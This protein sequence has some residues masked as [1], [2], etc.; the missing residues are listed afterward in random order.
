MDTSKYL[1]AFI[2]EA[3][4]NIHTLNQLLLELEKGK[5]SKD[6][7]GKAYRLVHTLKGNANVLGIDH[8]GDI[9][10]SMEDVLDKL[11]T[12]D[13]IPQGDVLDL[14]FEG[15][16]LVE[17]MIQELI[18]GG[19]IKTSGEKIV[20]RLRTLTSEE[21]GR[22]KKKKK[23]RKAKPAKKGSIMNND[24]IAQVEEAVKEGDS[25]LELKVSLDDKTRFK[26]GRIFQLF[27]N[28]SKIANIVTSLPDADSVD[29]DTIEL[30]VIVTTDEDPTSLSE[31][32]SDIKGIKISDISPLDLFQEED[33]EKE[34]EDVKSNSRED[35]ESPLK[36][37][38]LTKEDTV[39]VKNRHLDQ[40][41]DL[42]GEIMIS[43]IRVNQI[44][45]DLKHRDLKQ[46]LQN[47]ERL[48]SELQDTVLRMRMVPVDYIFKRFPRM[49]RDMAKERGK[50]I[51][52]RMMGNDMEIDRSLLDDIGDSLVHAVRNAIDHGIE[53]ESVRKK[54]GKKPRGSLKVSAY[55]EQSNIV[56]AIEDDGRG[57]DTKKI[58][59][60]AISKGVL[61]KEEIRDL[62]ERQVLSLAF[63]PGV[64]TAAKVTEVSGRGVGL[65]VVKT[66][67]ESLSGTVKV[68]TEKDKFTRIIM[69]LPPSMSIISAMLVEVNQEKYGIPLENVNETTRIPAKDIHEFSKS[70]VFRLRDE[71][72]PILNV[73][74]Q[75]GGNLESLTEDMPVVIVEKD[76][77]RAGLIVSKL[78]G[79]Q[80][81]VVKT[82]GKELA[83]QRYF[84]GATILGDGRV[85][86]ILDVGAL[87]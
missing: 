20:K 14:L 29:D 36:T 13:E 28:M 38:G 27:R 25:V 68:E 67:I 74:E 66:K 83:G 35:D 15:S 63:R 59:S 87:I 64:S 19:A 55:R 5:Y 34:S 47:R 22:T 4:E 71:I 45:I 11:K 7:M 39:R 76:D 51:D 37:K 75:F 9:A 41:L 33:S 3:R 79:Q 85:A 82:M 80:E 52:F 8:I 40:L 62:D 49:V 48:M 17:M 18:E 57:M 16:D 44:A 2:E 42:V 50:D 69:K 61:S 31:V 54:K 53:S 21:G 60:D 30:N 26:E 86:M 58:A 46:V 81:I 1:D 56:I 73:H 65:D 78:I 70:G 10:H 84:S 12:K 23:K 6:G 72:L 32:A 24:Q 43:D 77:A